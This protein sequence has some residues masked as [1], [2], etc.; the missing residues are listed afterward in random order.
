M[1][2]GKVIGFPV[3]AV[4]GLAREARI[5]AGPYVCAIAGGSDPQALA[6]ALERDL[7][8]GARAVISF[9]IAGGLAENLASGTW[10]I[11]R[12]VVSSD[13]HWACDT[14][15]ASAIEERLPGAVVADLA[16]V[17]MPLMDPAAKRRLRGITGAAAVDTESH[18]AAALA[19]SFGLPFAAF[20]VV[21][22][23]AR[24][25]LPPVAAVAL[26]P[27]GKISRR[28]VFNSVARNP[29]QF[30]ALV[31]TAADARRAFHALSRGRRLLGPG[32]A[33]PYLGELPF[34]VS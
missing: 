10:I 29:A 16:G 27:A 3:V 25:R 7:A 5:A 34:D 23:S 33:Y 20:R 24:R 8:F 1:S 4:T 14:A 9:G 6:R 13:G 12:S 19:K 31:R 32:L 26:T 18:I 2:T 11:G 22:D 15:W 30:P 21:A 28:A 17:E